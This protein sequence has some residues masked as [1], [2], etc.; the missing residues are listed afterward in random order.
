[1]IVSKIQKQP[2]QNKVVVAP[3]KASAAT[4]PQVFASQDQIRERAFEIYQKR[5]SKPGNDMQ[6]WLHAERQI[7]TH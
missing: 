3:G 1:M 5:G 6:D 7:L 2:K 4:L